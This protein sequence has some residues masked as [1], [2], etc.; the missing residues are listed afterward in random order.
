MSEANKVKFGLRNVHYA[1]ITALSSANVPTYGT[2]KPIKGAVNLSMD[3]NGETGD[4]FADDMSYYQTNNANGYNGTLELA[5]V[6]DTFKLDCLGAKV[7]K[8]GA[9]FD[10]DEAAVTPFA[11]MFEFNGDKNHTRHILTYCTA[12]KPA[13]SGQTTTDTKDPQTETLNLKARPLNG[14]SHG[15]AKVGDSSYNT[16]F[17]TPLVFD[18][19]TAYTAVGDGSTKS[20]TIAD[21]P[22]AVSSVK[23]NG[24]SVASGEYTYTSSTGTLAFTTAP[25]DGASIIVVY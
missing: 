14:H 23:V 1:P 3:A 7:D 6:P 20:F 25:A 5:L 9:I 12:T 10:D 24:A 16:W 13:V 11:L 15:E 18:E 19:G 21:K 17:E 8:T 2:V 4:F 22:T